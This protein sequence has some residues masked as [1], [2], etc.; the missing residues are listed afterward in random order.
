MIE[1]ATK[2]RF[3]K[4]HNYELTECKNMIVNTKTGRLVNITEKKRSFGAYINGKFIPLS[5]FNENIELIKQET[6]N[7][8]CNRILKEIENLKTQGHEKENHKDY[9]AANSFLTAFN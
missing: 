8:E 4:A 6:L 7:T 1:I 2:Y 5:K 9:N 3:K